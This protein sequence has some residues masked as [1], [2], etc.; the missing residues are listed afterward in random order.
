M[1]RNTSFP[2]GDKER[3]GSRPRDPFCAKPTT[4]QIQRFTR[5]HTAD[6]FAARED[7]RL[8]FIQSLRDKIPR[9]INLRFLC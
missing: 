5:L 9:S 8:P 6:L 4:D 3:E 7:A 2:G 1:T